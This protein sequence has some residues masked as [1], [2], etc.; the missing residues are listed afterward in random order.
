MSVY[1][2]HSCTISEPKF[3]V[4]SEHISTKDRKPLTYGRTDLN[5][6][7][8]IEMRDFKYQGISLGIDSCFSLKKVL[9]ND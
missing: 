5:V 9:C 3:T 2:E 8:V 6:E 7:V 4:C 1:C